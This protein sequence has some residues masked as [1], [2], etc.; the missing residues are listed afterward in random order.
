MHEKKP[1]FWKSIG[2]QNLVVLTA[3]KGGPQLEL[4]IITAP[5]AFWRQLVI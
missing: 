2:A 4:L 5:L 1:W 3:M